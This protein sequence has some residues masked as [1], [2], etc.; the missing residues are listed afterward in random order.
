[1]PTTKRTADAICTSYHAMFLD[2]G[3]VLPPT[4]KI[5]GAALG[6]SARKMQQAMY[7]SSAA[8]KPF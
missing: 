3:E 8:P 4:A 1:M 5:S 7:F 2:S 6:T